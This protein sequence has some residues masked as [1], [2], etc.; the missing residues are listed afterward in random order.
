MKPE[1]MKSEI[2]DK[3]NQYY[4]KMVA[5]S[6]QISGYNKDTYSEDLLS[7]C[8]EY[9]LCNKT[10]EQQYKI[11]VIDNKLPNWIGRMMSLQIKS[12]TSPFFIKYRKQSV[13]ARGSYLV[14]YNPN[15]KPI[16]PEFSLDYIDEYFDLPS[17]Q[18]DIQDCLLYQIN[19]LDFYHKALVVDYFINKLTYSQMYKKYNITLYSLKTSIAQ[20][21]EILKQ[22]CKIT[23]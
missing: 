23:L 13:N 12:S 11:A 3:I 21:V 1:L 7:Y 16:D 5:D 8:L 15:V 17:H 10:L 4:N 18:K 2:N 22:K 6:I 19:K 14:E 9:F 20:G